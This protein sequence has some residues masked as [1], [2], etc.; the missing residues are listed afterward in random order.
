VL[1]KTFH[2]THADLACGILAESG[3]DAASFS[4]GTGA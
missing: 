2:Y 3:V 4:G 1:D